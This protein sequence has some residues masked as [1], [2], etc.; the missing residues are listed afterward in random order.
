[1]HYYTQGNKPSVLLYKRGSQRIFQLNEVILSS[2]T[3]D[4][5]RNKGYFLQPLI[6]KPNSFFYYYYKM[7]WSC[8]PRHRN[9][10]IAL[11]HMAVHQ[12]EHKS[13]H[14]CPILVKVSTYLIVF[15]QLHFDSKFSPEHRH[16]LYSFQ[17]LNRVGC[18][19]V[20]PVHCGTGGV[21]KCVQVCVSA[22][23]LKVCK[24]ADSSRAEARGSAVPSH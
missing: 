17:G 16:F 24:L 3:A 21:R 12:H 8:I 18:V 9:A 2:R 10:K 7:G 23:G 11:F 6:M 15:Y 5:Q 1:M 22:R 19:P 20:L 14:R 4:F 13:Q